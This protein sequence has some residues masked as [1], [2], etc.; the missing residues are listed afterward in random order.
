MGT[1]YEVN[2]FNQVV[3]YDCG[4]RCN[5]TRLYR[6][7]T[8]FEEQL[9]EQIKELEKENDELR[10]ENDELRGAMAIPHERIVKPT[11][12]E[13]PLRLMYKVLD[14]YLTH[15]LHTPYGQMFNHWEQLIEHLREDLASYENCGI[16][17]DVNDK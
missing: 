2:G 17:D 16:I 3:P 1:T 4:R 7:L 5:D 15:D 14:K 10:E 12:A 6:D 8:N 9:L 11:F 13:I